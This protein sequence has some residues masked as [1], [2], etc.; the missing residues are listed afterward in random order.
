MWRAIVIAVAIDAI[1]CGRIGFDRAHDGGAGDTIV[2]PDATLRPNV[3]FTTQQLYNGAFGGIATADAICANEASTAGLPGQFIA[4][5][6]SSTVNARD[7]LAGSRGWVSTTGMPIADQID[8]LFSGGRALG[9]INHTAGGVELP[10]VQLFVWTAA[11]GDGTLDAAGTCSDWT[12]TT[13]NVR[14]GFYTRSSPGLT[15][16]GTIACSMNAHLY[17]FEIGNSVVVTPL[18]SSGRIA[19]VT[20]TAM[21][22]AT[23]RATFDAE[24]QSDAAAASLP[25][26]YL[27]AMATTTTTIASRFTG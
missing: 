13:G 7:R 23:G 12:S 9:V 6:S 10:N 8:D 5:L 15:T 25:G 17:C 21:T 18:A 14:I 24:C 20:Q 3:A 1:A 4:L 26:T 2:D 22:V 19:F 11:A 27:A 16:T